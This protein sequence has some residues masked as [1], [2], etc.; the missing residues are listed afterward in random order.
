MSAVP[1]SESTDNKGS[2]FTSHE[3]RHLF[4]C[5]I[6]IATF[7]ESAALDTVAIT[8]IARRHARSLLP[9]KRGSLGRNIADAFRN[10][11]SPI[12]MMAP[13]QL[14]NAINWRIGMHWR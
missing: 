3:R 10:G 9:I 8:H 5:Q 12:M 2:F 13:E 4:L 6:A 7:D 14:Q 1:S 11:E